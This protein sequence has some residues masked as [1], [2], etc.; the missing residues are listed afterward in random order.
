MEKKSESKQLRISS[1]K[2]LPWQPGLFSPPACLH[3]PPFTLYWGWFSFFLILK[4]I[5]FLA[6][7]LSLW[8]SQL[9]LYQILEDIP[10]SVSAQIHLFG[11]VFPNWTSWR[12]FLPSPETL[13]SHYPQLLSLA[14]PPLFL[15]P[16]VQ[17]MEVPRLGVELELQL[18]AYTSATTTWDLSCIYDLHQSSR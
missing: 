7:S 5:S 16:H 11:S 4:L 10:H 17:H 2:T 14:P 18:P 12:G 13:N 8:C 1:L 6:S 15:G 3:F 9:V